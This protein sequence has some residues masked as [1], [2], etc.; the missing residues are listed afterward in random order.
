MYAV[1]ER[2]AQLEQDAA[3]AVNTI[4]AIKFSIE[5][6]KCTANSFLGELRTT[7]NS[8]FAGVEVDGKQID[9]ANVEKRGITDEAGNIIGV[10]S[11]VVIK[12]KE[13]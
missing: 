1:D 6:G 7:L 13:S 9:T 2:I 12:T 5:D 11:V 4:T 8:R 10:K 3:Q